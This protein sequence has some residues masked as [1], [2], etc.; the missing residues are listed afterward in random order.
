MEDMYFLFL[1]LG[2]VG[3]REKQKRTSEYEMVELVQRVGY[4]VPCTWLSM[5]G[6][7]KWWEKH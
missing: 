3:E 1:P 4:L 7:L 5:R 6:D 2:V